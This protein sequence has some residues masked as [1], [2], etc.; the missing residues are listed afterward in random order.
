VWSGYAADGF[1]RSLRRAGFVPAV[2]PLHERG[3]VRARAYVGV[4]KAT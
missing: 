4:A 1:V 3:V 2:R